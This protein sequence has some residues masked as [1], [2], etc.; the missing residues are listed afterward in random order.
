[1]S[2][3]QWFRP[4]LLG[5]HAFAAV[6]LVACVVMGLWQLGV[7][8]SRQE[9]ERADSQTVPRVALDGLWGADDP[10]ESRLNQR[11]VT[12]DGEFAPADE[13]IWVAGKVQDGRT[14]VWL[15][16]PVKVGD[17]ALAVV[18]GWAPAVTEF[19]D[20]PAGQVTIEATL[21]GGEGGGAPFDPK[22]REIGAVRIPA[23]TNE[24][25]YDLYSGFAISTT[26]EV[27]GGLALADPPT[28]DVPWTTGLRN[29]AYALQWWVF[30]A[31][32][33]FMWWRMTT[34]SVAA[35]KPKVA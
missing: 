2:L 20:V 10:F 32:A 30:G 9:H 19:P 4:G 31:F 33:L 15:L 22:T 8:D 6:A 3:R 12:I 5:L 16:A 27:S 26:A 18:R 35:A 28:K 24:L 7:Y 14:G 23:L 1:M 11:P 13:Q 25:P 29:L 17:A 21:Q 34:E